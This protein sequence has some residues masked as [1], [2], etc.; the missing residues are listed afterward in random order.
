MA[1]SSSAPTVPDYSH[2]PLHL[3]ARCCTKS[4]KLIAGDLS[5]AILC[6]PAH[7]LLLIWPTLLMHL[8]LIGVSPPRRPPFQC[9]CASRAGQFG[10]WWSQH[11]QIPSSC[12]IAWALVFSWLP[13]KPRISRSPHAGHFGLAILRNSIFLHSASALYLRRLSLP[14]SMSM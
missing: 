11:G 9:G 4:G 6:A 14:V 8:C 3:L 7:I 5:L 10:H 2:S 13:M 1:L 12:P